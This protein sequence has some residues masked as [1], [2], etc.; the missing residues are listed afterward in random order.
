MIKYART[1]AGVVV[2]VIETDQPIDDLY[3]P[4]I[5][6]SFMEVTDDVE[7]GWTYTDGKLAAPV[8]P[9]LTAPTPEQIRAAMPAVSPRQF[10]LAASRINITKA[11]VLALVDAMEDKQA[12]ADMRIEVT[13]TVSF[14][15][16]NPAV[17]QLATLL[18]IPPEQL[19][20]LWTW[21]AQF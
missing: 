3:H 19:D 17:D 15:R 12:A 18:N 16:T 21:A 4:D 13:E 14:Q 2:E 9:T 8:A 11:D 1:H 5:T 6:A 20:S 7:P 10:W